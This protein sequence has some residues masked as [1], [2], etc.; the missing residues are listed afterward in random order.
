MPHA[1]LL[2]VSDIRAL[3]ADTLETS[4]ADETELAWIEVRRRSADTAD[5]APP[6]KVERTIAVRVLERGRYG[7]Y[8]TPF[9]TRGELQGAVREAL[10]LARLGPSDE[11]VRPISKRGRSAPALDSAYDPELAALDG[12]AAHEILQRGLDDQ[13][14]GRLSWAE[15]R[16]VVANSKGLERQA[17]V[18]SATLEITCG[19]GAG[20]G[21]AAA[22]ARQL[23]RLDAAATLERARQ[24][25]GPAAGGELPAEPF[26]L[27]LSAEVIAQLIFLLNHHALS[28]QSF[29]D[30]SSWLRSSLGHQVFDA[31]LSLGDR[32][33]DDAGLPFPFDFYGARKRN[34]ELI[35][36]GVVRSP[37]VDHA[38]STTLGR[39]VT[40]LAVAAKESVA[41]NLFVGAGKLRET[42]LVELTGEGLWIGWIDGLECYD[43]ATL[44][45]RARARGVRRIRG[46]VRAESIG[47]LLW[48]DRLSRLFSR[49]AGLGREALCLDLR[50]SVL[51][52]IVT[53]P[54]AFPEAVGL[55]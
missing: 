2:A 9:P 26:G 46:G 12:A 42:E 1:Q 10:G 22:S 52:G 11:D 20:A 33:E 45:F 48:E 51:G 27:V 4:P 49:I 15:A 47:E 6:E 3:I 38:L 34:I 36:E 28:A 55:S 53:P 35:V 29:H 18:T 16:V 5:D 19:Q 32:G 50:Q 43:P 39:P 37:A 44:S 41:G 24:R 8:R 7:S 23:S 13:E 54:M 17:E 14:A 31:A 25:R 40:P 21:R 30:E